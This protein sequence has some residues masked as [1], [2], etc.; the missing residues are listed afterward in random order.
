MKLHSSRFHAYP[1]QSHLPNLLIVVILTSL[2]LLYVLT[3]HIA[4]LQ[5]TPPQAGISKSTIQAKNKSTGQN[6]ANHA[7]SAAPVDTRL[8]PEEDQH[9]RQFIDSVIDGQERFIRGAYVPGV[10]ALPVIQQPED[11]SLFVASQ[12]G[13]LTQYRDAA[14]YGVTGLIAHNYLSGSYFARLENGMKV[15]IVYGDGS[16]KAYQVQTIRKFQKVTPSDLS[17]DLIDLG[18]GVQLSSS[19]VFKELYSGGDHV[20][21]Q[22][23]LEKEGKQSW[24]LLFVVASPLIK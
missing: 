22:T 5:T 20:T 7:A 2:T 17:S 15:H 16:T 9:M 4:K 23:C 24:G 8:E 6:P 14:N 21:F 11:N 10:L 13:F 18:T 1:Q 3:A 19:Q 12:D